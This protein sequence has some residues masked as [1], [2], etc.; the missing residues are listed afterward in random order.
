ML[1]RLSNHPALQPL[2]ALAAVVIITIALPAAVPANQTVLPVAG[3]VYDVK[4]DP[5]LRASATRRA[6]TRPRLA[7]YC[8]FTI[9]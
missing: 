5:T 8:L 1:N 7:R 4:N 6:L 9:Q 3:S 2:A